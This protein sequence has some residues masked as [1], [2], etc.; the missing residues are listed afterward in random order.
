[1]N[2]KLSKS[3]KK[4]IRR[5]KA[6]IRRE[7]F[8][9]EERKKFIDELYNRILF[10]QKSERN[11]VLKKKDKDSPKKEKGVKSKEKKAKKKPIVKSGGNKTSVNKNNKK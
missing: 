5:E 10:P 11:E 6:R 1:M 4:H 2:K 9:F 7:H 3:I 8:N